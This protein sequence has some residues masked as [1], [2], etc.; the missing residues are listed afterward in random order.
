MTCDGSLGSIG[1]IELRERRGGLTRHADQQAV[2]GGAAEGLQRVARRL[3]AVLDERG[4]LGF[5]AK[6]LIEMGEET[7]SGG[8]REPPVPM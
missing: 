4:E 7:G 6:W 1:V 2:R 3:F 5:N 8:L